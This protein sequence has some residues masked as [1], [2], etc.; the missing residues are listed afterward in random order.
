MTKLIFNY[1]SHEALLT[2]PSR[3][4]YQGELFVR[5]PKAVVESLCTWKSLPN[6]GFPLVF[7]GIRVMIPYVFSLFLMLA[8]FCL[9]VL[10]FP[11]LD[12]KHTS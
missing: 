1:R 9:S 7:H 3:L 4:F 12:A 11:V 10:S 5:A 8:P 6:K 2:L